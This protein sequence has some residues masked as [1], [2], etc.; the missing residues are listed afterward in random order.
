MQN[1]A[2]LSKSMLLRGTWL[3]LLVEHVTLDLGI[4]SWS[5]TLRAEVT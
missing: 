3:A 5:P 2:S 4:A 1:E